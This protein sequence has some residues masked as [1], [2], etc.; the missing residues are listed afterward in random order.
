MAD[1]DFSDREAAT[2]WMNTRSFEK[3]H[4]MSSRA[5]LRVAAN[6]RHKD[7][8]LEKRLVLAC[9]WAMV[10]SACQPSRR[11]A[12]SKLAH[13]VAPFDHQ[14]ADRAPD[15]SQTAAHS[16]AN[17]VAISSAR[18]ANAVILSAKS[19]ATSAARSAAD[20]NARAHAYDF[21]LSAAYSATSKDSRVSSADLR[22]VPLWHGVPVPDAIA[23]A[24]ADFLTYLGRDPDWAFFRRFYA[25]M[26]EGTFTDW[27]L[28]ID[29]ATLDPALW[30][31]EDALSK[32]AEATRGIEAEHRTSILPSIH[33]SAPTRP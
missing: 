20:A 24:H 32:G 1:V 30:K 2:A 21:T 31:G 25:E 7:A 12:D 23:Q 4:A 3:R 5:A 28:A 33:I 14:I 19:A 17:S 27:D 11:L 9:F 18:A 10:F 15:F 6:L 8:D 26:W 29:V 13:V 22:R 16:A